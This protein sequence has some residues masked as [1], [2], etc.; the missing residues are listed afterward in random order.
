MEYH[1]INQVT[2]SKYFFRVLGTTFYSQALIDPKTTYEYV[3][4]HE[5]DINTVRI[6]ICTPY[7]TVLRIAIRYCSH[8][9]AVN[10]EFLLLLQILLLVFLAGFDPQRAVHFS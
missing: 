1:S 2:H 10:K 3:Q 7:G 6:F 4:V 5:H 9:L 8:I